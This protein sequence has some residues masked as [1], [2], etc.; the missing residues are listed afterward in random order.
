LASRISDARE[1]SAEA[2]AR[3]RK[4]IGSG[5]VTDEGDVMAEVTVKRLGELVRGAFSVLI[6]HPDG[7]PAAQVI[8]AV[9]ERVAP[10]PFELSMYPKRPTVRRFEKTVRFATITSVKAGWLIK[11]K[12]QWALTDDGLV[13]YSKFPDPEAF[14]REARRLYLA[15][16]QQQPPSDDSNPSTTD[17]VDSDEVIIEG[18]TSSTFEEAEEL[19]WVEI[20]DYLAEMPP[21]DF[22][23]LVA[24][25]LR[26]MG[27]HVLWVAP[28]GPDRGIDM[29]AHTDPLGATTPRIKAQVKRQNGTKIPVDGVRSFIAVLGDQDLGIYVSAGG[30]TGEAEREARSQEKRRLT[31]VNLDR[32][33]EL[34]I[35]YFGQLDV[36]DRQRLPLKPIYFLAPRE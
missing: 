9:E 17:G 11:S 33:V 15:W 32:L 36:S 14:E 1:Y 19:A 28:P 25:L 5:S 6:E 31:L 4:A 29:I 34:W 24:A 10:T 7:L 35:E 8:K 22:Q 30:F 12:G 2:P 3:R 18:E 27:Y 26:G 13:A 20:R 23:D 16:K 21:Y